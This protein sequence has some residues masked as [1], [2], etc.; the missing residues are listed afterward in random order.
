MKLMI[1]NMDYSLMLLKSYRGLLIDKTLD[2]VQA[3]RIA[4]KMRVLFYK[5]S[6]KT[7]S[8]MKEMSCPGSKIRILN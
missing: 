3:S 8:L 2:Q 4:I 1:V 5:V 6:M 7:E